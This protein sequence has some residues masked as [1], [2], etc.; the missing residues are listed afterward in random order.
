MTDLE[1]VSL[2][3]VPQA[4]RW[5]VPPAT[6]RLEA[7]HV[8]AITA[9]PQTDLFIDPQ[10]TAAFTNAPRLLFTPTG[11][12][13]LQAR[14]RVAFA[15]TFD[16]GVLLLYASDRLWAKLCF[17]FSPQQQPMVVSVVTRDYSDDANA[18]VVPDQTVLLRVARL[19]PACAFHWSPDGTFWHFVRHFRLPGAAALALGFAAQSPT[20]S[21]CTAAFTEIAFRVGRLSDLRSG[22]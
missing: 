14:V 13:T 1:P 16:A 5:A 12:Y 2:A 22:V 15:A 18:V 20:G 9:G 6:W 3:G 10:Q 4:M 19:G 17:E 11:D 8:L 7:D 21:G